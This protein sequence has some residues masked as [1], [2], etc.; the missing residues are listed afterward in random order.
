MRGAGDLLAL[1]VDGDLQRHR[2]ARRGQRGA[3]RR[4]HHADRGAAL[5]YP[6]ISL[7]DRAQHVGLA[8]HVVDRRAVAVHEGPVDL[9]G[10][11]EHRRAGGE[12]LDLRAAAL[13]AA[14]PVLVMT[15]P[16]ERATRA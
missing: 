9:G 15:T 8:R 7:R 1:H 14:V 5:P 11:V 4:L 13:P 2:S 3:R 10:D 16:S 6:E 12:R